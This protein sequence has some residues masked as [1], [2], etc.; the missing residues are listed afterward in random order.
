MIIA[1]WVTLHRRRIT[2]SMQLPNPVVRNI[3]S[4]NIDHCIGLRQIE[5][6]TFSDARR[7]K[8]VLRLTIIQ[9]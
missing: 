5:R 6:S 7:E 4:D 9:Y 1:L 2:L 3:K 8:S